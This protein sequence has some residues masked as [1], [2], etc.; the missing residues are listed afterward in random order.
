MFI[1]ACNI[2]IGDYT[3]TRCA[4]VEIERSSDEIAKLATITMPITGVLQS[5]NE[6]TTIEIAKTIKT[7]MP[8]SI[9]L[10]YQDYIENV[11]F[12]GYVKRINYKIPLEIE[13]EDAIYLI[14]KKNINKSW[15]STTLKAVLTEILNGTGIEL[16]QEPPEVTLKPYS[17][18]NANGAF[19]LQK[20]KDDFG[21][22]V[23]IN[24]EDKLYVGLAYTDNTGTVKYV[25]NGDD[26][27]VINAD[28]L[29]YHSK[30]DV[31]L[32]VKAELIHGDNTRTTVEVGDEDGALRDFKFY[33][34]NSRAE[35]IQLA[36]QELDKIKFDGYEGKIITFLA[37]YAL[38]GMKAVLSDNRFPDREGAYYI[39]SVKTLFGSGGAHREIELGIKLNG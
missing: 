34:I 15:Q 7:G 27:N 38:P 31:R 24:S 5:E 32:K 14:R 35:L 3:F 12:T 11:E 28:D 20:I 9:T 10:A 18:K 39:D 2:T 25:L 23:Y 29:K 4:S 33:N 17:I 13:C 22:T 6:T 1:L 30:D 37:P 21:L 19:A 26:S 16:A 36:K 8:V